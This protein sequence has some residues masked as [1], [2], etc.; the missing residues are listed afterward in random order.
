MKDKDKIISKKIQ[1]FIEEMTNIELGKQITLEPLKKKLP[2]VETFKKIYLEYLYLKKQAVK[3]I[4]FKEYNE[5]QLKYLLSNV[6]GI[7]SG[8]YFDIIDTISNGIFTQSIGCFENFINDLIKSSIP[9]N[10]SFEKNFYNKEIKIDSRMMNLKNEDR[11]QLLIDKEI[12]DFFSGAKFLY[13]FDWVR[14]IFE[15]KIN[16]LESKFLSQYIEIRENRNL[17]LHNGSI[18]NK[19]YISQF[20]K[21]NI[22]IGKNI[23]EGN[24]LNIKDYY[25]SRVINFLTV[26]GLEIAFSIWKKMNPNMDNYFFVLS[27]SVYDLIDI[28]KQ[29]NFGAFQLSTSLIIDLNLDPLNYK[30]DQKNYPYN[31][32]LY[33][34]RTL[35]LKYSLNQF[36]I[37][38]IAE[39]KL[40][41]LFNKQL[42][43]ILIL[44]E[45]NKLYKLIYYS[46]KDDFENFSK[47]MVELFKDQSNLPVNQIHPSM[48][49]YLSWKI[50]KDVRKNSDFK[51]NFNKIFNND[52]DKI[53][54][55]YQQSQF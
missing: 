10:K 49:E 31:Y 50:F 38:N 15:I 51:I 33:I 17:I 34:N 20:K 3:N 30:S 47:I 53:Y 39:K 1:K 55:K 16:I 12:K 4:N 18:I 52:F 48:N 54:Y 24:K 35:A 37:S 7:S 27:Q 29:F 46:L 2:D 11:L 45:D 22:K 13:V 8:K 44:S 28:S 25:I 6:S 42:K 41:T 40:K 14:D 5:F 26:I 23:K 9:M 32:Y 36:S 43:E 21:N 19:K